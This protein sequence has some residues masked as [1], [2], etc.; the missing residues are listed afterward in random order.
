MGPVSRSLNLEGNKEIYQERKGNWDWTGSGIE[1]KQ[2]FFCIAPSNVVLVKC[3]TAWVKFEQCPGY[4]KK[5]AYPLRAAWI[6]LSQLEKLSVCVC[7]RACAHT[8][9]IYMFSCVFFFFFC[10]VKEKLK[11][12][13][14]QSSLSLK[15]HARWRDSCLPKLPWLGNARVENFV[16][17]LRKCTLSYS[18]VKMVIFK[19]LQ[20]KNFVLYRNHNI[21]FENILN[22][23]HMIF[24]EVL[25][26][27]ISLSTTLNQINRN[28]K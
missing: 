12:F 14:Y 27:H 22:Q 26:S 20:V 6:P 18:T 17:S 4:S 25:L 19:Y 2:S 13:K 10:S 15:D 8:R 24:K 3:I 21:L 7:V 5:W 28:E 1:K 9:T 11:L 23:I 16:L